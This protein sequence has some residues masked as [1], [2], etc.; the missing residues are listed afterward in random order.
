MRAALGWV[1]RQVE[2]D[3]I[4]PNKARVLIYCCTSLA[5]IIRDSDLESRLD[6][7]EAQSRGEV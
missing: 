6:A 1:F 3:R 4:D 5:S 2:T 7:L